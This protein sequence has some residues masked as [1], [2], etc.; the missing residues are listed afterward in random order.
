MSMHAFIVL[1]ALLAPAVA[2]AATDN[3]KFEKL[4][5]KTTLSDFADFQKVKGACVCK[6]DHTAGFLV[7]VLVTGRWFVI[8]ARLSFDAAGNASIVQ[9]PCED[10]ETLN[11]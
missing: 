10:W 4:L 2:V 11:N 5:A 7:R 1:A 6:D 3:E 9:P 8:C